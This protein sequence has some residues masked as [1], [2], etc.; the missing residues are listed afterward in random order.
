MTTATTAPPDALPYV[1]DGRGIRL[2]VRI[3]PRAAHTILDGIEHDA[4]GR[5]MLRV[6]VAA[7]P[8]EGAANA[9]LIDFLAEALDLPKSDV[10]ILSGA[11]SRHKLVHLNGGTGGLGAR[12]ALWCGGDR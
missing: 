8:V 3:V 12:L 1:V 9:A 10:E 11:T 4:N 7:P 5:P 6:R 2:A